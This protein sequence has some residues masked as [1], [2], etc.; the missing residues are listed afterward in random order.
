MIGHLI[1]FLAFGEFFLFCNSFFGN[2]ISFLI[3]VSS[4]KLLVSGTLLVDFTF[5]T[6]FSF[7]NYP[8]IFF[9][10]YRHMS[11]FSRSR[12]SRFFSKVEFNCARFRRRDLV[13]SFL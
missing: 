13:S 12:V 4:V 8:S 11:V 5:Q 6:F 3:H 10:D 9:F 1:T 2:F 7:H